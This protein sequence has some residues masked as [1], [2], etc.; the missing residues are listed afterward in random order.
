M[1][2]KGAIGYVEFAY[3]LQKKLVY[4]LV[5]N[6]AGNFVQPNAASFEAATEGVDW[7][8]A[9]DFYVLLNNSPGAEAYPIVATS[10][11]LIHKQ[12]KD[13]ERNRQ[14]LA[15]FR[16]ALANGQE[17]ASSLDYVPLPPPL[18]QRVEAYWQ[19]QIQ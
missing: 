9:Q 5:Q 11:V 1:R 10:F 18:V 19:A 3:V 14:T 15:F 12:P 7:E 8:K 16:W 6:R 2:I 13:A 17:L 4:G